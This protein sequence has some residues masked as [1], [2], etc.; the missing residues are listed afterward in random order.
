MQLKLG[1]QTARA[2]YFNSEGNY[3]GTLQPGTSLLTGGSSGGLEM[4]WCMWFDKMRLEGESAYY[5]IDQQKLTGAFV[6]LGYN[7]GSLGENR[8]IW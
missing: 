3:L 6:E 5:D 2:R 4:G 8:T 1:E 7:D